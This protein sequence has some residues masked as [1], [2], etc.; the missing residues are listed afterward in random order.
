MLRFI[1]QTWQHILTL[2]F[3][4]INMLYNIGKLTEKFANLYSL[5]RVSV[6]VSYKGWWGGAIKGGCN[7]RRQGQ[8]TG[9]RV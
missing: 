6:C 5:A 3:D 1:I 2:T 4:P 9:S 8:A 7:T